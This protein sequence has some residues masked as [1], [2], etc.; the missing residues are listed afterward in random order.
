[1]N[2]I[3]TKDNLKTLL[4]KKHGEFIKEQECKNTFEF[5][6]SEPK[7]MNGVYWGI[8]SVITLKNFDNYFE[9]KK[10]TE[11][12]FSCWDEQNGAFGAFPNHDAHILPTL[13]ALQVL[14]IFY[15]DLNVLENEKQDRIVNFIKNLQLPDGSFQG[16]KYGEVDGRFIYSSLSALMILGRLTKSISEPAVKFILKCQNYDYAFGM[17]PGHESHA[18][19]VFT[20]VA[21]LA[22]TNSLHLINNESKLASWLSERQSLHDGGLNGRP[23]K[24][25]DVCYSWWVFASLNILKKDHWIDKTK[26]EKYILSCQD[27]SGGISDKPGNDPDIFHTCF[28]ICAL[29]LID[30]KKFDIAEIDS[31]YCMPSKTTKLFHNLNF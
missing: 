13:S 14:K 22:I 25:S 3:S 15:S 11:F 30:H 29:S 4:K 28:G 24:L 5:L 18:A 8:M 7:R 6:L 10:I 21:A 9:K 20:C 2:N 19:Y 12:I 23:E 31:I 1:M 16:D 17:L 26:L 27:M